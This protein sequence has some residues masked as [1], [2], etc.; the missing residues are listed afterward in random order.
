M[1]HPLTIYCAI[2]YDSVA[3]SVVEHPRARQ[4]E[5]IV[6]DYKKNGIRSRSCLLWAAITQAN[7]NPRRDCAVTYSIYVSNNRTSELRIIQ[8]KADQSRRNILPHAYND[9]CHPG[10]LGRHGLVVQGVG[11]PNIS[12]PL[13]CGASQNIQT[14]QGCTELRIV[15]GISECRFDLCCQVLKLAL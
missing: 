4:P 9:R 14:N 1:G 13:C 7:C 10:L 3:L 11:L 15:K 5:I 12:S 8:S 6:C 2:E